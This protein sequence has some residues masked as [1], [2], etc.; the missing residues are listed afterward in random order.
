MTITFNFNILSITFQLSPIPGV[1]TNQTNSTSS[2]NRDLFLFLRSHQI[3]QGISSYCIL[4]SSFQIVTSLRLCTSEGM[5]KLFNQ[6]CL[7]TL[8]LYSLTIVFTFPLVSNRIDAL[9]W[10]IG[11]VVIFLA[12]FNF[13]MYMGHFDFF[14]IYVTMFVEILKTLFKVFFLF[15]VLIIAFGLVFFILL[16]NN[17]QRVNIED[18]QISILRTILMMV[19]EID[20]LNS[21]ILPFLSN[22]MHYGYTTLMFL[23]LFIVLVPILLTNLLVS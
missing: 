16:R 19:G 5:S 6:N 3:Y 8:V 1:A 20:G 7:T 23:V 9:N 10:G 11:S 17:N 2:T 22:S 14:G 12:W 4:Y 21:F 15:S 13:L 18:P